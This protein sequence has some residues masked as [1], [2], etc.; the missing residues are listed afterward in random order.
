M[1]LPLVLPSVLLLRRGASSTAAA[2]PS[3]SGRRACFLPP[4]PRFQVE[5][6]AWP[7]EQ[8]DAVDAAARAWMMGVRGW[9]GRAERGRDAARAPSLANGPHRRRAQE[10]G[11]S[12]CSFGDTISTNTGSAHSPAQ[13]AR[14]PQGAPLDAA[15]CGQAVAV[16]ARGGRADSTKDWSRPC[17]CAHRAAQALV[18]AKRGGLPF[19]LQRAVR[20]RAF[21]A[22]KCQPAIT[23]RLAMRRDQPRPQKRP[24]SNTH[25]SAHMSGLSTLLMRTPAIATFDNRSWTAAAA[26]ACLN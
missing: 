13:F 20:C 23:M 5:A 11:P 2:T 22:A 19:R 12:L 21:P 6:E 4:R 18:D 26:A 8:D 9:G 10:Q 25:Q 14:V 16:R 1:L 24:F 17:D 7:H 15:A 3:S